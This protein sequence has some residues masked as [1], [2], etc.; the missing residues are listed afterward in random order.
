MLWYCHQKPLV[1]ASTARPCGVRQPAAPGA[2]GGAGHRARR[3]AAAARAPPVAGRLLP[4]G[5]PA[6]WPQS[7]ILPPLPAAR[8]RTREAARVGGGVQQRH[9][10]ALLRQVLQ[11]AETCG[12]K[13]W[14]EASSGGCCFTGTPQ[15][16]SSGRPG[17]VQQRAHVGGQ[18]EPPGLR[19]SP[20]S[21]AQ[22]PPTTST[23]FLAGPSLPGCAAAAAGWLGFLLLLLVP[24]G[25]L[26]EAPLPAELEAAAA[27]GTSRWRRRQGAGARLRC[28]CEGRHDRAVLLCAAH[29]M[30][31]RSARC[32][33]VPRGPLP[34]SRRFPA[35]ATVWEG[36]GNAVERCDRF[37][38]RA[39]WPDG[40]RRRHAAA[41]A[42][43]AAAGRAMHSADVHLSN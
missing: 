25:G 38:P 14:W 21:P 37:R 32:A 2:G 17:H 13:A 26:E 33:P 34:P 16:W 27:A 29:C 7:G 39:H 5:L 36:F 22:P 30:T 10:V 15:L 24:A 19:L 41:A 31:A 3:R 1:P 12:T 42:N 20:H 18:H 9:V 23:R 43:V 40:W 28:C 35:P 4:S 11:R 6:K 8:R